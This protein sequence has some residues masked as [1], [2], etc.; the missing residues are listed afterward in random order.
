MVGDK[1]TG[2]LSD[3]RPIAVSLVDAFDFGDETVHSTLGAYD[4]NVYQRMLDQAKKGALNK[5]DVQPAFE[6]YL[7]PLMKANL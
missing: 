6:K 4:G 5:E 3:L 7:K 1:I 2:L